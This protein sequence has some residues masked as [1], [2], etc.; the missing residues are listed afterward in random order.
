MLLT[1]T[2]HTSGRRYTI[3]VNYT[4]RD[5]NLYVIS[6]PERTWWR[7]LRQAAPVTLL[8][9][10]RERTGQGELVR[11]D[12]PAVKSALEGSRLAKVLARHPDWPVVRVVLDAP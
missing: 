4:R 6:R 5:K 10:G 11:P 7:N 3:P 12:D 1:V 2:G 9:R 8:L